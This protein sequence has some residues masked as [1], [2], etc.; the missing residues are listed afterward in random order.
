MKIGTI[1]KLND[2][3]KL[4]DEAIRVIIAN[5]ELQRK[6]CLDAIKDH[7]MCQCAQGASINLR[8]I[9]AWVEQT[10]KVIIDM[11]AGSAEID[12]RYECPKCGHDRRDS[13]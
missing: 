5:R 4:S 10:R 1:I 6:E 9:S 7:V 3:T 8:T 11:N 2:F 12:S 13:A